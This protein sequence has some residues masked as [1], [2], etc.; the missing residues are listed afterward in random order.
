MSDGPSPAPAAPA[1]PEQSPAG[2]RRI[3]GFGVIAAMVAVVLVG[4][5]FYQR[6][7]HTHITTDDAAVEGTIH[8]IAPR[9]PGTVVK[10]NVA[11]N[12]P[13][14]AGDVLVE[15]DPV[16]A[17]QRLEEAEAGLQAETRRG[18][19]IEAQRAAARTRVVAAEAN[20][21]R[22][23]AAKDE[24][25]AAVAAR[26][27]DVRA[28]QALLEQ[29]RTDLVRDES[30]VAKKV[31]PRDRL[32]RSR[33]GFDTAQAGLESAQ[34]LAR[35]AAVALANHAA[36]VA[37]AKA[38]VE[39]ERAALPQAE[40]ALATHAEQV[41]GREAQL[42]MARLNLG[43]A[44]VTAPADGV[45]T[46]KSVEVGNQVLA[47][48]PLMAL[49]TTADLHVIANYKET[50][51]HGIRPGLRARIR[52]DAYP[53]REFTGRVESIMAGT[54]AAFSLFPPE[55]ASG[56]YVKVVQRVPVK[57]VLDPGQG[58]EQLL[59]IGMSVI[60]TVLGEE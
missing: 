49:V 7:T 53:G 14:R 40:A 32:E 23:L 4:R 18:G 55:N 20:L 5:H 3:I 58:A 9:V 21:A 33:T 50:Q 17:R 15:I 37:Q 8:T 26:E 12:Q 42:G 47:G 29:A 10:V 54:G 60:P 13:V 30:L 56:N 28:K 45:V 57:I 38:A 34:D 24:L 6:Y 25:A 22:V 59:R 44:A 48:Q 35:Q 27:A 2:R 46:R 51:L 19:E 41:K 36:A 1:A 31:I 39:V 11:T 43:W 52:V 16:P